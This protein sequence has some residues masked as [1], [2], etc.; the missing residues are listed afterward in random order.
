MQDVFIV[1]SGMTKFGVHADKMS[2]DLGR[3]AALAAMKDAGAD[4]KSLG[5]VFY[6]NTAQGA[7][8]G[9]H[10]IRGQHAL[11]PIGIEGAPLFNVENACT[12]SAA[13]LH[14]AFGQIAGGIVDVALVVGAE[15]LHSTDRARR[16]AVFSQPED[17]A[18]VTAFVREHEAR[19]ADILPPPEVKID[20]AM[21]SVFMDAYSVQ[22]RLHMKKYGTTWRQIAQAS[23][24]NHHHSTMNPLAQFTNDISVDEVL[25]ARVISWPM[26]LP[27]C[28]PVSDG[29]AA[30]V[31]CSRKAL[32]GFDAGRAVRVAAS[33]AQGGSTRDVGDVRRAA[34]YIAARRAY[35][36]A[37]ISPG[38]I[39]VAEVHDASA[40][41]ELNQ[42]E[43]IG[44]CEFGES[45]RLT[46]A[47]ATSLGGRV[48]VNTSG[49]LQS[50][51]HPIAATGLG[52]IHELVT[53][54]RGEAGPRQVQRAAYAIASCGGGFYGVEEALSCVTILAAK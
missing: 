14:L 47:G 12:G 36:Q 34:N 28:A 23:S 8:E 43:M 52:Q 40:Y 49:G 32:D 33:A 31:L 44:L 13:A 30:V 51:G 54:L 46:E 7:I 2:A 9:Q 11:R 42:I 37:G 25:A 6:A 20:E 3:D 48:P 38:D 16:L 45:G 15:K 39:S 27:M 35:D 53:Q 26:T 50:K 29:A 17:L 19:V 24:K 22:A 1:G 4:P 41:A 10:A 5:A 18:V 21:R